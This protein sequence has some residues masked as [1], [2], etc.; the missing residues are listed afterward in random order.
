[1]PITASCTDF[2]RISSRNFSVYKIVLLG[3]LH[4]WKQ[5]KASTLSDVMNCHWLS[6]SDRIAFKILLITYKALNNLAPAY[7]SDLLTTYTP[8]YGLHSSSQSLLDPPRVREVSTIN[9]GRRAF[10]VAAPELWNNI[11]FAIRNAKSLAQ[12]KRLLKLTCSNTLLVLISFF[13]S[14]QLYHCAI[15]PW[16]SYCIFL[17]IVF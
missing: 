7:I 4:R 13:M 10:S 5:E 2:R 1:M 17:K 14:R 12:F 6:V 16:T 8:S 11:P 9:Y 3:W 15:L